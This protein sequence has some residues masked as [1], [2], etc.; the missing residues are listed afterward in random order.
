MENRKQVNIGWA[1]V[2]ITPRRPV[3]VYGQI[4]KR[5]SSY[6]RDPL[7]ATCMVLENGEDQVI[8]ISCDLTSPPAALLPQLRRNLQDVPG[9]CPE[10]ISVSVIHTHNAFGFGVGAPGKPLIPPEI[11]PSIPIP[12]DLLTYEEGTALLLEQLTALVRR[13][14]ESREPGA[15]SS[16]QDYAAVAFNRRPM[17]QRPDCVESKMYG[18][19]SEDE[20]LRFEGPSDHAARMLYTWDLKGNLTG[21]TVD[22]PC[23]SQVFELHCFISADYWGFARDEIRKRLGNIYVLSLC[24][25][26]GDQN[27]LDLVRISKTN[28]ESLRLW[29]AQ[30]TEVFR[31]FDMTRECDM[32]GKRIAEAVVRGYDTAKNYRQPAPIL[33]HRVSSLDMPV[34]TVTEADYLEALEDI[35]VKTEGKTPENRLTWP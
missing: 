20:F 30:A 18:D 10:K 31:N 29:N 33:R 5:V 6:V 19:C 11:Q 1:Q 15:V 21:V 13:A 9:L 3:M 14:W 23:P 16:A 24:G 27:P 34:R 7:S 28:S 2:D 12:A 32:I 4:Y 26:A 22:I 35:R 8:L 17:F 25:A